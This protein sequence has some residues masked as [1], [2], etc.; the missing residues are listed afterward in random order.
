MLRRRDLLASAAATAALSPFGAVLAQAAKPAPAAS[1][2]AA[3]FHARMDEWM[4]RNLKRSPEL[5][6][7]LGL[8]K[9]A[10]AD[11]K[12]HLS[13]A[14]LAQVERDGAEGERRFKEI[15]TVDRAALTGA[16]AVHYDTLYYG[17]ELQVEGNRRFPLKAGA[18][19]GALSSCHASPPRG[20]QSAG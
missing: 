4:Q 14:D 19:A 2:A 1:P 20:R 11:S 5:V 6:T 15:K 9:G 7:S 18:A 16:D 10:M 8:D 13:Q 17:Q 12:R 3:R